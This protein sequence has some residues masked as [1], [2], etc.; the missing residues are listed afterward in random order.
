MF[1]PNVGKATQFR[2]GQ[3]GNAGG[4]PKSRLLSQALR[5]RL[6]EIKPGDPEQRSWAEAIAAKPDRDRRL[7]VSE[8]Y[9]SCERGLR[10]NRRSPA[11]TSA[12]FGLPSGPAESFGSGT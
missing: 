3:T 1:D 11:A 2:K 12:N 5:D 10:Q 9:C 6:G 8:C 7:E 4:R